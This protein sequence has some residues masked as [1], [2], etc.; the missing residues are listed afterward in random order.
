MCAVQPLLPPFLSHS[1]NALERIN[2]YRLGEVIVKAS[3]QG[4]PPVFILSPSSECDQKNPIAVFIAKSASNVVT[5]EA[6]QADV[7]RVKTD[8]GVENG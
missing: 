1:Q 3:F 6:R 7:D 5:I 4:P 8:W 2:P